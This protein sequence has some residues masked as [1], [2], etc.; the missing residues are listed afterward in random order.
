MNW[1]KDRRKL[2]FEE[3]LKTTNPETGVSK[4]LSLNQL[5]K[6]YPNIF[7]TETE[8]NGNGG[9]RK[10]WLVDKDGKQYNYEILRRAKGK[11]GGQFACEWRLNG[12]VEEHSSLDCNKLPYNIQNLYFG[13]PGTGKSFQVSKIIEEVYPDIIE[14][15]NPFVFRTTVYPD[16]SYYDFVGTIMPTTDKD[17]AITYDFRIGVFTKA[18]IK[19]LQKI[20]NDVFL[21]VEEMSRGNIA[22][23]FGDIFQLLDRNEKGESEYTIDNDLITEAIKKAGLDIDKVYLPSNLHILGTVNTS[24]QN[25]YVMDTAFKRRFGFIYSSVEPIRDEN[26]NLMNSYTFKLEE[27]EFEWNKFY[28]VINDFIVNELNLGEDKQIGQFFIKFDNFK[29]MPNEDDFKYNEIQNKLLHYLWEDIKQATFNEDI[30]IF[31]GYK[32]FSKLYKDFSDKKNVFSEEFLTKYN[33][34]KIEW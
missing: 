21:V 30:D 23:I 18:L 32:S 8:N 34:Q 3:L 12:F 7:P 24:D 26:K 20:E 33:N 14:A 13:A 22:S 29:N 2:F 25:V 28:M 5:H 31:N 1:N 17:G 6:L 16:Y 11:T 19:A 10:E 9:F 4:P 15:E 27:Q